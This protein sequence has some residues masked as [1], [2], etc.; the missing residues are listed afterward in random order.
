MKNLIAYPHNSIDVHLTAV[1]RKKSSAV[2]R[3]LISIENNIRTV[4]AEYDLHFHG[5][6]LEEI[7][8]KPFYQPFKSELQSLYDY[9]N[10]TIKEVKGHIGNLQVRTIRN[11][12]QNCTIN[13]A[14]TLDHILA[15]GEFPEYIVNPKNLFPCCSQCNSYKN[16]YLENDGVKQFL[17]LYLDNLPIEQY[18]FVYF[19]FDE[20]DELNFIY[21]LDNTFEIDAKIFSLIES[22][23][24]KLHLLERMRLSANEIYS[25]IENSIL[26]GLNKLTIE[27]IFE[28]IK[29]NISKDQIAYG[30]N[31]WKCVLKL[32]LI[33]DLR[34][35]KYI[36]EKKGRTRA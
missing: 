34:Y 11:T 10:A 26:S 31:H 12:C 15:Q 4:Y 8:S 2:K 14:N 7:Q 25:E 16:K 5:N 19:D 27:M 29:E 28:E 1:A 33:N 24:D 32:A 20:N 3:R 35:K 22:H 17:N 6:R 36:V 30:F 23:F 18:L 9:Q 21:K 13:S